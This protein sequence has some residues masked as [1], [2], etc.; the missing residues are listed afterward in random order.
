MVLQSQLNREYRT[1]V[2]D[3][4]VGSTVEGF[5]VLSLGLWVEA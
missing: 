4:L 3:P 5:S 1:Q 2:K